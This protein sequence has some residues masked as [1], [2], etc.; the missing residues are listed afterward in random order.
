VRLRVVSENRTVQMLSE[1]KFNG[2]GFITGKGDVRQ[3]ISPVHTPD[4]RDLTAYIYETSITPFTRGPLKVSAQGFT[5]GN[6]F[7]GGQVEIQGGV[8]VAGGPPEYRLLESDPVTLHVKP[9]PTEGRRPGF[10]GAIGRFTRDQPQLSAAAVTAGEP[11]KLAVTFRS[12]AGTIHLAMPPAPDIPDWEAFAAPAPAPAGN[13]LTFTYTFIPQTSR[14]AATPGIP[15]CSFDP[16]RG[17]YADLSIPALPIRV[18]PGAE[19]AGPAG[20]AGPPVASEKKLALSPL[21][22]APGRTA[23]TLAPLQ[24]RGWFFAVELGP[25]PGLLVLWLASRRR[26]FLEQHPD[27]LRR[28]QARRALRREWRALRRAAQTMDAPGFA[29]G[30]LRAIRVACAPHF[31]AEPRALVCADVL[32]LLSE[33]ERTGESGGVVRRLFRVMDAREYSGAV[34]AD[35]GARVAHPQ[36]GNLP[37]DGSSPSPT[38]VGTDE[39]LR[40]GQP[41]SSPAEE[42]AGLLECQPQLDRLL[43]RLEAM[44]L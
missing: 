14:T 21:A 44:L 10:Y 38:L 29:T 40:P 20:A 28:R 43:A 26:Q 18:L 31:P 24:E 35:G 6:A 42:L 1:V 34:R 15:F 32:Q 3:Q 27:L 25:L 9:V 41:Q 22:P 19:P 12:A 13:S 11:V 33:P 37:A 17:E 23:T 16:D 4:G 7:G 30:A 36:P 2:D 39:T 5:S 8:T